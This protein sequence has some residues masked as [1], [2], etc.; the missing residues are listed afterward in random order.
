M[1]PINF[2]FT[3]VWIGLPVGSLQKK[4]REAAFQNGTIKWR[5]IIGYSRRYIN[6]FWGTYAAYSVSLDYITLRRRRLCEPLELIILPLAIL[7]LVFYPRHHGS[8]LFCLRSSHLAV[9][10]SHHPHS[11]ICYSIGAGL[12]LFH[13]AALVDMNGGRLLDEII[14]AFSYHGF[15]EL[16]CTYPLI[17]F[18]EVLQNWILQN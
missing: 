8:V 5:R 3:K 4:R 6:W 15:I 13:S 11:W 7:I 16:R 18:N 17:A 9:L 14:F 10:F 1:D 2:L 12:L